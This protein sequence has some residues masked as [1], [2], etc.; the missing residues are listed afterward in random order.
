MQSHSY[1]HTSMKSKDKAFLLLQTTEEQHYPSPYSVAS[2]VVVKMR[3]RCK[4]HL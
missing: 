4:A 2:V 3:T 1:Q